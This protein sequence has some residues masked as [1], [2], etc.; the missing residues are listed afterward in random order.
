MYAFLI[1]LSFSFF[2]LYLVLL[3]VVTNVL[4]LII[5]FL[6]FGKIKQNWYKL[7][8]RISRKKSFLPF[9]SFLKYNIEMS[10]SVILL[11]KLKEKIMKTVSTR[12]L[13]FGSEE[14]QNR[15]AYGILF[16]WFSALFFLI[17]KEGRKEGRVTV[18][19]GTAC[20]KW[21]SGPELI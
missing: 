15:P 3:L 4:F 10:F 11:K 17:L 7:L 14:L 20:E 9:F 1:C 19:G 12:F 2:K 6:G 18:E 13:I 8:L 16:M 5:L 21:L